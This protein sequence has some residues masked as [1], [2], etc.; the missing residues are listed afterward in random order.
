MITKL[1]S[2]KAR[3]KRHLRIRNKIVGTAER[4]RL[5]VY[6]SLNNVYIQLID[7][8]KGV[9][10][11]SASTQDA[12][13]KGSYGGNKEAALLCFYNSHNRSDR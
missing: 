5:S 2:N 1:S 7:D 9:T 12:E 11:V 6:R 4:P 13:L 10:L 8:A 3:Q